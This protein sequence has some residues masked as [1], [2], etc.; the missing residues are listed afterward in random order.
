MP[1]CFETKAC[2]QNSIQLADI[3]IKK[4]LYF[5]K[6]DRKYFLDSWAYPCIFVQTK[7]WLFNKKDELFE[8]F[9]R[10]YIYTQKNTTLTKPFH[11]VFN[12]S[13]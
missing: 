9:N 5:G 11:A 8:H 10:K 4:S 12:R 7:G 2:V 1:L 6:T 13:G 3:Y